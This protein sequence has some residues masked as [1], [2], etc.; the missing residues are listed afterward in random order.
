MQKSLL[1]YSWRIA[2][3]LLLFYALI[4]GFYKEVPRLPILN[5][6]IRNLFFHVPMWWAMMILFLISMVSSTQYLRYFKKLNDRY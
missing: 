6:T 4:F 5:E 3:V 2:T 1:Y